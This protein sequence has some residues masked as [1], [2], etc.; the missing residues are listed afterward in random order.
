[1]PDSP[2]R[3]RLDDMCRRAGVRYRKILV[4]NTNNHV[5]NAAVMGV[6][7]W[8]RYVLLSD[9]LLERMND[10]EIESVF[11]HELGHIVHRH[12]TWYALFF[13][14]L[15]L[16]GIVVGAAFSKIP[17]TGAIYGVVSTVTPAAGL[18]LF[19]LLFG[20]LSRRCERQADVYA[21]RTMEMINSEQLLASEGLLEQRQLLLGGHA[22]PVSP[23]TA[24][25]TSVGRVGATAFAGALR[26]VAVINNIP[27]EPQREPG[28]GFWSR[29]AQFADSVLELANNW[30]HGSIASRMKYV[31]H[32]SSDS[33]LT[34]EFDRTMSFLYFSL[35]FA[36]FTSAVL[37]VKRWGRSRRGEWRSDDCPRLGERRC[38]T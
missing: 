23:P 35:L 3:R 19:V 17:D 10:R 33:R 27:I 15:A 9:V 13:V 4:W 12:M 29:I 14:L 2:L 22:P 11:A 6:L 18:G 25:Q 38:A 36:L 24:S 37:S 28:E 16:G 1:M 21:A 5:G 34:G 31:E 32:L 30:L 7:P 8:V 20:A 26:R